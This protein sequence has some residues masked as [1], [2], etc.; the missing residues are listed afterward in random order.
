M[1]IP[2]MIRHGRP[3]WRKAVALTIKA[4]HSANLPAAGR[5]RFFSGDL[6]A[7]LVL[8]PNEGGCL[9]RKISIRLFGKSIWLTTLLSAS[10]SI[11]LRMLVIV[12][13]M[14][15]VSAKSTPCPPIHTDN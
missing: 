10:G 15:N 4:Y 5:L 7:L 8:V 1:P 14:N 3:T 6:R 11:R 12:G 13:A 9:P 2:K